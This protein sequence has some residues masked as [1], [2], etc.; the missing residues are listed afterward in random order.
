MAILTYP[1]RP[2]VSNLAGADDVES[3]TEFIDYV[4]FQRYAINYSNK[5]S[6]YYGQNLPGNTVNKNNHPDRIYLAIPNQ[7][8]T[9]YTPSY[10]QVDLGVAGV[11]AAAM[12]STSGGADAMSNIIRSAAGNALPEFAASAISSTANSLGQALGLEG[13]INASTLQALTRGKV[14]NP[15]TEQIFKNMAF[16]THSFAFKLFARNKDE[17]QEIYKIIMYIKEGAVPGL[18][19]GEGTST[20]NTAITQNASYQKAQGNRF[21]TVPDKFIIK[22]KRFNPNNNLTG[23]GVAE[24]HH[25]IK[26]SVCAGIQVNYTPDGSYAAFRELLDTPID[27][28]RPSGQEQDPIGGLHVPSVQIQLTFIE[29]SIISVNDIRAGY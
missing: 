27:A 1:K 4:M 12:L 3:P 14:F 17:A 10:N 28:K 22:Y 9:Q 6:N 26:D 2:P 20:L 29:T 25:R 21:F 24:L 19:G 23:G 5:E 15:F 8:S 18:G 16:R 13:N 7:V 11:T